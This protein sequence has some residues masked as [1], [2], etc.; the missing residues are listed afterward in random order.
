MSMTP[1]QDDE[2][3]AECVE[4]F[5]PLADVAT[6][7]TEKEVLKVMAWI[8]NRKRLRT[9]SNRQLVNEC[10]AT[11]APDYDVVIEMMN[12]L[13]PQWS[14][15]IRITEPLAARSANQEGDGK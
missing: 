2:R 7:M 4:A 11:D 15:D 8:D 14:A 13:D 12:R 1:N 9:L 3:A 6:K 10:L 5:K